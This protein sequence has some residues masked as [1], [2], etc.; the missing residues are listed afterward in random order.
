MRQ[1]M[2]EPG[3]PNIS[4]HSIYRA[5][6]SNEIEVGTSRRLVPQVYVTFFNSGQGCGGE[7]G[8]ESVRR[9]G[10]GESGGPTYSV[11]SYR[12]LL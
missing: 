9:E 1:S 5:T 10:N 12:R 6:V 11:S 4:S 2:Q 7:A 8:G 3:N